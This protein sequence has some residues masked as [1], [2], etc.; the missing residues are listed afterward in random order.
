MHDANA[1]HEA[2]GGGRDAVVVGH[3]WGALATYGAVAHQPD[4]GAGR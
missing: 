3:D 1:L 2:F 4:A